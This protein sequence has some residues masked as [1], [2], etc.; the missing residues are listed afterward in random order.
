MVHVRLVFNWH[1]VSVI[2]IDYN[3][4]LNCQYCI[5][6]GGPYAGLSPAETG[7]ECVSECFSQKIL[8][9]FDL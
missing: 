8:F 6:H 1:H 3:S 7:G 2:N 9:N 4:E 5:V